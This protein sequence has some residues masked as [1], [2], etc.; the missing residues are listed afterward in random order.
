VVVITHKGVRG[1]VGGDPAQPFGEL[2]DFAEE[3]DSDLIDVVLGDHTDVQYSGTHNGILVHETRS[4]GGTYAK[5]LLTVQPGAGGVAGYVTDKSVAFV[6]PTTGGLSSNNT[7]CGSLTYCDQAIVDMLAPYRVQLAILLDSV[8][9]TTTEPFKRGNNIER[10]REMPIGDLVADGM[11]WRYGTQ[12]AMV[13]GGGIRS[14]VPTCSYSPTNTALHRSAWDS[15]T[16][17]T[18]TTCSG[19]ASGGPYDLVRGDAFAACGRCLERTGALPRSPAS[20]SASGT[21]SRPAV[22]VRRT[23]T[24]PGSSG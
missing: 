15:A 17:T 14:Q 4:Y 22:T 9:G 5:T 8:I 13:N 23:A 24:S 18:I 1:F 21:T 20:S 3:V 16:L 12:L 10:T 2:I 6:S 19:Y 11:R 7:S